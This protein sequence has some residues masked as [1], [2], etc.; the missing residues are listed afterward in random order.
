MIKNKFVIDHFKIIINNKKI[1][2]QYDIKEELEAGLVLLGWEVKS[3]RAKK[4]NINSNYILISAHNAY[5]LGM[6]IQP[7][8]TISKNIICEPMRNRQLLL[9]KNQINYLAT[10]TNRSGYT[11]IGTCLFWKKNW[12]KLNIG[13]A[14]GKKNIDKRNKE[15]Q[16]QWK[17]EKNKIIKK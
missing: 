5:L 7:I 6:T 17:I 2:Y 8:S 3:I 15:K 1:R 16:D 10:K 14:K 11:I 13:I 12:C 9:N 4:V